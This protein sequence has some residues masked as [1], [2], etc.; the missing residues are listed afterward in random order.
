[1]SQ[2]LCVS[3][4]LTRSQAVLLVALLLLCVARCNKRASLEEAVAPKA[5]R[6]MQL[7]KLF[8]ALILL[9]TLLLIP[10]GTRGPWRLS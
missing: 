3:L 6:V 8:V 7:T 9:L 5:G 10:L 1:M 2:R 4:W